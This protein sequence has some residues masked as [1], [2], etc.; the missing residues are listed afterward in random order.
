MENETKETKV[1]FYKKKLLMVPAAFILVMGLAYA[2]SLIFHQ[3]DV[4]INVGEARHSDDGAFTFGCL[5]GETYTQ[6]ASIY[7]NAN[8]NLYAE[9]IYSEINNTS[10][11][12][13]DPSVEYEVNLP[14]MPVLLTH[15]ALTT[16]PVEVQDRKSVG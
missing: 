1:P 15:E 6:N 7:N 8:V 11:N 5:S 12:P 9:I 14:T 13:S 10:A 16:V 3:A 2:A 4:T